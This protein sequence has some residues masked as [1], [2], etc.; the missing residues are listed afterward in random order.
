[1][2]VSVAACSILLS[3][4]VKHD[5]PKGPDQS[6]SALD[7]LKRRSS[8]EQAQND[9][10]A[11]VVEMENEVAALVPGMTWEFK[12]EVSRV[13]CTDRRFDGTGGEAVHIGQYVSATPLPDDVWPEA[14]RRVREI[15]AKH[16]ADGMTQYSDLPGDHSVQIYAKGD[17]I[18]LYFGSQ[19]NTV[20]SP[21]TGCHLPAAKLTP[22]TVPGPTTA[23]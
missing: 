22:P 11:M 15:A 10:L 12:R 9:L 5:D 8:L 2:G 20:L 13:N 3:G 7:E 16:G 17:G 1:M 14:L 19:V 18:D 23:R 6:Q 4:C 21:Q